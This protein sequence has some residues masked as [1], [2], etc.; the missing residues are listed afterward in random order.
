MPESIFAPTAQSSTDW[1]Q[2]NNHNQ[3]EFA[4]RSNWKFAMTLALGLAGGAAFVEFLHAQASPPT[5]VITEIAEVNDAAGF[6]AV[7]GRSN[8]DAA[9]RNQK[10]GAKYVARTQNITSLDGTAPKRLIILSFADPAK[11]KAYRDDPSQKEIDAIRM[12]TTTSRS[13][14]AEGM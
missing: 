8:A 11:A 3:G 7:G 9:A 14:M 2:L 5:L 1:G 4:M 6:S 12:K 10:L 13:F